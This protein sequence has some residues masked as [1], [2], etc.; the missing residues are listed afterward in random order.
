MMTCH[1]PYVGDPRSETDAMGALLKGCRE[2]GP[3]ALRGG[4]NLG[5]CR[6][7][8]VA[9]G[10]ET[11]RGAPGCGTREEKVTP[12]GAMPKNL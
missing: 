10:A 6:L 11:T 12:D 8:R 7:I 9:T 2:M 1:S 3:Y 5:A 4:R